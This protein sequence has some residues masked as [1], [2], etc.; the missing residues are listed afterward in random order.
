MVDRQVHKCLTMFGGL[1]IEMIV[2]AFG[3]GVMSKII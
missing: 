1:E 3:M 2:K